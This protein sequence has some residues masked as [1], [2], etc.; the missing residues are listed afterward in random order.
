MAAAAGGW[1]EYSDR[2]ILIRSHADLA[3]IQAK[4]SGGST[5]GGGRGVTQDYCSTTVHAVLCKQPNNTFSRLASRDAH[6]THVF[7]VCVSV[8]VCACVCHSV[9]HNIYYIMRILRYYYTTMVVVS[10]PLYSYHRRSRPSSMGD[11]RKCDYSA[12]SFA[13]ARTF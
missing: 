2:S 4:V 3:F 5:I 9:E 7:C 11:L 8:C 6:N 13:Y 1:H 10:G 12:L